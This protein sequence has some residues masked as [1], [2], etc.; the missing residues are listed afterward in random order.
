M[1]PYIAI[2]KFK[3]IY[4]L[5]LLKSLMIS[6]ILILTNLI[7][8]VAFQDSDYI[9]DDFYSLSST[10]PVFLHFYT[11]HLISTQA[12]IRNYVFYIKYSVHRPSILWRK[13]DHK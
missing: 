5:Y 11:P 9:V 2:S 13:L 7:V 3:L 10:A 6:I 4:L 8:V 12:S 1:S